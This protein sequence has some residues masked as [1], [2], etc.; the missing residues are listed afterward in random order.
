MTTAE[1]PAKTRK[2]T[3]RDFAEE[4]PPW[5]TRDELLARLRDDGVDVSARTLA[6]WES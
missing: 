4:S 1:A 6:Y 5:L 3:W 2:A